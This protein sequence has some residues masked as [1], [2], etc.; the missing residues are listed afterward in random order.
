MCSG[1][2]KKHTNYQLGTLMIGKCFTAC[3]GFDQND[4]KENN[5]PKNI[6]INSEGYINININFKGFKYY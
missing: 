2:A 4:V 3:H 6:T 5:V 1:S